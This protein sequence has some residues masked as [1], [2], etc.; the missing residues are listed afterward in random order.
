VK[1]TWEYDTS[2]GQPMW[3]AWICG[4]EVATITKAAISSGWEWYSELA[5][6]PA[7]PFPT[8]REAQEDAEKAVADWFRVIGARFDD[9]ILAA[10]TDLADTLRRNAEELAGMAGSFVSGDHDDRLNGKAEGVR[11]AASKLDA[12]IRAH[13]GE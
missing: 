3:R 1:V 5:G 6:E 10:L 13:K 4:L 7:E 8:Y 12:I 2:H 9:G 11:L